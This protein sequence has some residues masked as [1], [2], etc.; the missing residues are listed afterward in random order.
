MADHRNG[1]ALV[2]LLALTLVSVGT[3]AR[4][5]APDIGTIHARASAAVP[6]APVRRPAPAAPLRDLRPAWLAR[7]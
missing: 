4:A 3:L 7:P 1:A 5:V 6:P 2:V